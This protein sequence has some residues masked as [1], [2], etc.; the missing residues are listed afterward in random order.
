MAIA[1]ALPE[2]ISARLTRSLDADAVFAARVN[3][4][5]TAEAR[6]GNKVDILP[7]GSVTVATYDPAADTAITYG[8][9]A[10]GT[11]ISIM[12]NQHKIAAFRLENIYRNASRCLTCWRAASK[13]ANAGA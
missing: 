3:Q 1:D 10:P 11:A 5:Y 6:V 2:I 7:P 4:S 12:L 8:S 13:R 9:H